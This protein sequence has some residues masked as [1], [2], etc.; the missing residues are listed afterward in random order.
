MISHGLQHLGLD[1]QGLFSTTCYGPDFEIYQPHCCMPTVLL[2]DRICLLE[3]GC[4]C[5]DVIL[6][7]RIHEQLCI[8]LDQIQKL[9]IMI[10]DIPSNA[11]LGKSRIVIQCS[12]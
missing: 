8:G 4:I 3:L 10:F 11:F 12:T 6:V 7:V 2:L 9:P 1:K 5:N